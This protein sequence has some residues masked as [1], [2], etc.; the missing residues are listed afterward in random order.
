MGSL[1]SNELVIIRPEIAGRIVEFRFEE[2]EPVKKGQPLVLLDDFVWR[3]AVEQAE[4]ALELSQANHERAV[5]L[6]QRKAGTTKA[7]DEAF[8]QMRVD[9]AVLELARARLD[10]SVI[11]APFDGVVGLR[12]VSIGDFVDV[13]QDM[14]NPTL[15]PTGSPATSKNWRGPTTASTARAEYFPKETRSPDL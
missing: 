3:S 10:K 9:Q 8:S 11:T 7:R 1:R 12:K 6:L 5:D 14:V 4:A 15:S 13:G 2:G